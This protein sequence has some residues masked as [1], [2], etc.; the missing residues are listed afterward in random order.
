MRLTPNLRM[1]FV[2]LT[3]LAFDQLTKWVVMRFLGFR[4]EVVVV[5]GF[6]RLV[7][8][9]NTGAAWSFFKDHNSV[10]AA[11]STLA[12]VILYLSRAH[13]GGDYPLGQVALGLLFGGITGNLTD[14][15]MASRQHVID[16]LYFYV[17]S[18]GGDEIGFPAFN[19]ADSAICIGVTL[20]FFHSW[21]RD[22]TRGTKAAVQQ[23]MGT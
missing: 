13:F 23:P 14:R 1:L 17:H 2:A 8:W 10:L 4:D 5:D 18:R 7:H 6:F 19:V 16:F 22:S 9:G 21:Q 11:V 12:L 20:L 15:L 3:V